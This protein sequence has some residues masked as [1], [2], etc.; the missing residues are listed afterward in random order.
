MF[1]VLSSHNLYSL[2]RQFDTLPK[3]MTTVI[4][5]TLDSTFSEQAKSYCEENNI[6][7]MITESDGTAATGKNSF[8]DIFDKDGVPYAV[9]VDGD[10]YLTR[11]G[12]RCYTELL[13]RDDAPDVLALSNALSIGFGDTN[14]IAMA[15][16]ESRLSFNPKELTSKYGQFAEVSDWKELGKGEM[17][18][19]LML[20]NG[21]HPSDLEVQTFQSYIRDLEYGMG[22]DAIATR[23]TF[24]SR[25]VIPY[26]FKNLVV[27]EDTLQYLELKDAH[28]KGELNM[29]V[30]DE[31][32]PTYMYDS[33][34][35]GIATVESARDNGLGFLDW[36]KN[37]AKEITKLKNENR[38]HS[39]RVPVMEL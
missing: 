34:L 4:I 11:R 16:N 21:M 28:E 10:D 26:K 37:L 1:Y 29:V 9:L 14:S 39:S 6:R 20:R 15:L 7:H 17:V 35:S 31:T 33:R 2:A 23:I 36:M 19:D 27:G 12:V 13:N 5:N 8:L 38:L 24:M 30:H 18:V 22:M 25:K 3:D 32:K